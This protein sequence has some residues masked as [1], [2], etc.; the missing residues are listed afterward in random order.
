MRVR[1]V[2]CVGVSVL[3]L[4]VARADA[5]HAV[6]EALDL[7]AVLDREAVHPG[8]LRER[9]LPLVMQMDAED[10]AELLLEDLAP[11]TAKVTDS[12]PCASGP[13]SWVRLERVREANVGA[14]VAGVEETPRQD[15]EGRDVRREQAAVHLRVQVRAPVERVGTREGRRL[16]HVERLAEVRRVLLEVHDRSV[17]LEELLVWASADAERIPAHHN[18]PTS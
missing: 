10:E 1:V 13:L 11:A 15:L 3:L 16:H 4:G 18:N 7:V 5:G 2:G 12:I 6:L 9:L 8:S 17:Q 14:T